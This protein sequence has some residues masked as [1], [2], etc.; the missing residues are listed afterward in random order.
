MTD[1]VSIKENGLQVFPQTHQKAVVGLT[2]LIDEKLVSAGTGSVTSVNGKTGVVTLNAAD[3]G[4][5]PKDTPI[6]TYLKATQT[7]DGLM[8]KEDKKKLDELP[9][10]TFTKVGTV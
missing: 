6:P 9:K 1:I 5:I 8:S 3:I 4:A 7:T 2:E 10:I